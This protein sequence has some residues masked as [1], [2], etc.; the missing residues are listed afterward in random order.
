MYVIIKPDDTYWSG[1]AAPDLAHAVHYATPELAEQT[2]RN[3]VGNG[4]DTTG[5]RVIPDPLP[6]PQ[7]LAAHR[8]KR[9]EQGLGT[10]RA[11]W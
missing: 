1:L 9:R 7:R 10:R 2:I 8:A 4:D 3:L 6:W 5:Y 11:A